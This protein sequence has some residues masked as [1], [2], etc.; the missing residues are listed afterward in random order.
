MFFMRKKIEGAVSKAPFVY[1]VIPLI[2]GIIVQSHVNFQLS[3]FFVCIPLC[4]LVAYSL[5]YK[6]SVAILLPLS[7]LW[8]FVCGMY[9]VHIHDSKHSAL[10]GTQTIIAEIS[11]PVH[12]KPKT[13][14]TEITVGADANSKS[15]AIVYIQKDSLA[16]TLKYGDII[17]LSANFKPIENDTSSTFDYANYMAQRYVYSTAYV[18]SKSWQR[19]GHTPTIMSV[20]NSV[21]LQV[22]ELLRLS[23]LQ[24]HNFELIAA[25][26]FGNKTFLQADV[27][28]DFS[29]A[30]AMH[31][32][33][34]SGLH[35][36]IIAIL[37]LYI[38]QLIPNSR[39]VWLKQILC[40][41]GIWGYACITGLSPSVFRAACM[42]SLVCMSRLLNR[43]ISTYNTLAAAACCMLVI[44]PRA[45]FEVGFQLSYLAVIGIVYFG[46]KIQYLI[47][48]SSNI[49][50][51][52]VW[53]IISVSIAV[54]IT[55]VPITLY[56]FGFF[57]TYSLLT[58]IFAIPLAFV[59]LAGAIL[60][61]LCSAIP[62]VGAVI[63]S[64]VDF[65]SS[66]LQHSIYVFSHVPHAAIPIQIS[67]LEM[68]V[69]YILIGVGVYSIEF[70]S[71]RR[72]QKYIGV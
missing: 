40:I 15:K 50:W 6:Y 22:L 55:T 43:N 27:K 35:V 59:L 42:F 44:S 31:I 37:L 12:E 20:C 52:Y 11:G 3:A 39:L 8:F 58:N 57:P 19:I 61:V 17:Y 10:Y 5:A 48:R 56:Y 33:A 62:V 49:V 21:Q 16:A 51:N 30:G 53:G 54:Q 26:V 34:V 69:M 2:A 23:G 45:L 68:F 36:G 9:I 32:L 64:C 70:I 66:Y 13:Y 60:F 63:I 71:A 47:P 24:Q 46:N 18:S 41:S 25:L 14:A 28:Q 29:T 7:A 72:I 65:C 38:L 1:F 67:R 4:V